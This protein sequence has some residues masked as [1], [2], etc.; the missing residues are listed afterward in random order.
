M[1]ETV[2]ESGLRAEGGN[3]VRVKF[4]LKLNL[5]LKVKVNEPRTKGILNKLLCTSGLNLVILAWT[6]DE[7]HCGQAQIGTHLEFLSQIWP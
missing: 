2:K 3:H 7:L 5:I 1:V 4:I 6:S